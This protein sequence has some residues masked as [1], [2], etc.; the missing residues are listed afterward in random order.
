MKQQDGP[1]KRVTMLKHGEKSGEIYDDWA[2]D[3]DRDLVAAYGYV[4]PSL[5]ADIFVGVCAERN[6]EVV[7]FGCG[8]GLVGEELVKR[9]YTRLHGMDVSKQML[10]RARSKA[11]YQTL[12]HA[13]LTEPLDVADGT[14]DS[15][16]CV[17]I[18]GN[19]HLTPAHLP[20]MLRTLRPNAPFV[21]YLNDM[22]Y[23][24]E[25]Y[26]EQFRMLETEGLWHIT[27]VDQSN[28]MSELERPGWAV[29]AFK[30]D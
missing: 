18:F 22:A 14:Y 27:G 13:D 28:Y 11:I 19:G 8:T 26:D 9:G 30:S 2:Q 24:G 23:T 20:E 29:T 12:R 6:T 4:G 10:A 5:A 21:I 25:G 3:Y 17:G 16:I 15:A 1:L 7:D